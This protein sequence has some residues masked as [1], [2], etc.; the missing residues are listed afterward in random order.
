MSIFMTQG[1]YTSDAIRGMVAKPEDRSRAV[2]SLIVAAGGK[3]LSYYMTGR[4]PSRCR[5][6]CLAGV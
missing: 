4:C 2:E 6:R 1:R 3:M 5:V